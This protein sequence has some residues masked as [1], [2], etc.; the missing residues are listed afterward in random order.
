MSDV[1]F[2]AAG[3]RVDQFLALLEEIG[4]PI[5]EKSK[6][7]ND[8]LAAGEIIDIWRG[9]RPYPS[10][11]RPI[12]RAALGFA[13]LAGKVMSTQNSP[14]F[15]KLRAHLAM[16]SGGSTLQNTAATVLDEIS[17]KMIEL[18]V[19]CLAIR[20]GFT[21]VDVD[22]PVS[23]AGTNPDVM[24]DFRRKRWAIAL[25][26]LH[27]KSPQ[28]VFD[29]IKKASDQIQA[30]AADRG[31]VMLNVKNLLRHDD[32]WPG[33]NTPQLED[34]AKEALASQ[35]SEVARSLDLFTEH[36]W[37]GV[38]GQSRKAVAPVLFVGHSAFS[39]IP[40]H[41]STGPRFT[42]LKMLLPYPEPADDPYG[43]IKLAHALNHAMQHFL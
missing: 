1:T 38:F 20:A 32:L 9:R 10:D 4:Y 23:S 17:N 36:D 8:A 37:A 5:V 24:F 30:S 18:Y 35:I 28:T 15:D 12:V 25:K 6:T 22:H 11:P 34:T 31:L 21:N 19:A 42:P 27:S 26:T 33:P 13:D 41:Q 3:E 2:V 7:E 14:D 16:L 43:A 39:V 29:N 40:N